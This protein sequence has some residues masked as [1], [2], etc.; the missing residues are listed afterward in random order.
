M[1]TQPLVS[2]ICLCYN[3]ERFLADA[4]DSVLTQTYPNIEIIVV[5][6]CSTDGSI[7]IINAYLAKYPQIRFISTGKNIGNCAA[8]NT[9]LNAS[10]GDF[11]ID[12][13]TD[14]VLLP[15]R[16][17]QQVEAFKKV[18]ESYGVVYSDAE[19]ITDT[20]EH[21]YFHSQKYKPAPDGDVF[22]EVLRRYF[23]CPPT[24]LIRRA[25]FEDLGGYDAMLAYEDFDFWIRSARK[26]KYHYLDKITTQ[27]RVH[28][29]SLS[30]GLYKAGDKMLASTVIVCR[31][32][33]D[34]VQNEMEK[35]ALAQRLKYEA[36]HAYLTGNFK[37]AADLLA[38]L[39]TISGL[40]V[41]Y[42]LISSLNKRKVNL[43]FLRKLY[44]LLRY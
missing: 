38:I 26:Y 11:I 17:T 33:A 29:K 19:Y 18:D 34:L 5:D 28:D 15:E 44:H 21:L 35:K 41:S 39:E 23:I 24:M 13:A 10:S 12:F 4:L 9:G 6:D 31:K 43:S 36:R 14:D 8:F 7:T 27:R 20:S 32:A 22:A 37:E 40:P 25:V 42:R 16:I 1:I 3:H 30:R 2:V